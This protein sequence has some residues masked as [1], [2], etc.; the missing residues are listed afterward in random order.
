VKIDK[1]CSDAQLTEQAHKSDKGVWRTKTRPK[2]DLRAGSR[3]PSLV[4]WRSALGEGSALATQRCARGSA[5]VLLYR[6][7][8]RPLSDQANR[9]RRL[10][11][12]TR[13]PWRKVIGVLGQRSAGGNLCR[14]NLEGRKAG[15]SSGRAA[16]FITLLG[17]APG[18]RK[19]Y[20]RS[21]SPR[22]GCLPEGCSRACVS[23][24][25]TAGVAVGSRQLGF[26]PIDI[27]AA[28]ICRSQNVD[29]VRSG[30]TKLD[31]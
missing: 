25:K 29:E 28:G 9:R 19:R 4:G 12:T 7:P 14:Q 16:S 3:E 30:A 5:T 8:C 6:P 26:N 23:D 11:S 22:V 2:S 10:S 1:Q 15:R 13:E 18:P 17:D 21:Y 27:S 24:F 31:E 20:Q